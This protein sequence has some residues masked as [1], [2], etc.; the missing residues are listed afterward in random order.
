MTALRPGQSP[1]PVS[2]PIRID[3]SLSLVRAAKRGECPWITTITK[4]AV[5][6]PVGE[7]VASQITIESKVWA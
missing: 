4:K 6:K 7:A 2:I 3:E 1:P 5:G